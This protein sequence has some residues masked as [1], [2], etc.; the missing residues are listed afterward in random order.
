MLISEVLAG[1]LKGVATL[2]TNHTLGDAVRLFDERNISSVVIVDPENR[3][4][5]LLTDR[6]AVHA[7]ARHGTSAL[8]MGVTHL[9]SSPVPSCTPTTTVTR[10]MARMTTEHVRHLVV[11]VDEEMAGIVSIGDLV[12]VRLEEADLEGRILR[13]KALGRIAA[14]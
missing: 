10:A 1:K 9:M 12:K 5:G 2:W 6:H 7:L 4:L 3:P 14:D 8:G 13:D 11:M